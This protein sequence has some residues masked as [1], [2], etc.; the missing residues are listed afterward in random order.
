MRDWP[1]GL[2]RE[3][4]NGV[5]LAVTVQPASKRAGIAGI[6]IWRGRLQVSVKAQ[7]QKG[8][9]NEAVCELLSEAFGIPLVSVEIIA[10]HRSRQKSVRFREVTLSEVESH[11]E[12]F[13][14]ES[15]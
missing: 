3:G 9:A 2:L 11:L 6:D 1:D 14:V 10:G 7:P 4:E 12:A 15:S 8:A 5:I 13:H